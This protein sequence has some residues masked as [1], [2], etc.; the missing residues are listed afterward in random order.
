MWGNLIGFVIYMAMYLNVLL[1]TS[2]KCMRV[3]IQDDATVPDLK[4]ALFALFKTPANR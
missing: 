4:N 1:K 2:K 3:K